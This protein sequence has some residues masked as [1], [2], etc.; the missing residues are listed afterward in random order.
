[1]ARSLPAFSD[2]PTCKQTI[3]LI[4]TIIFQRSILTYICKLE[5][6]VSWVSV[7]ERE[8][9]KKPMAPVNSNL[10]SAVNIR[11]DAQS[12]WRGVDRAVRRPPSTLYIAPLLITSFVAAASTKLFL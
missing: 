1:M 9:K 2:L 8:G 7:W 3:I 12:S 10:P 5:K 11:S 6:G 4:S